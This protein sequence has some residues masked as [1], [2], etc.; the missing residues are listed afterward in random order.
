MAKS[1]NLKVGWSEKGASG[2]DA[3]HPKPANGGPICHAAAAPPPETH[4]SH[5]PRTKLSGNQTSNVSLLSWNCRGG[6]NSRTAR[7]LVSLVQT[8]S[9]SIVFLCETRQS[10]DRMKRYMPRLGLRG[11]DAVDTV[12]L[13]GGLALY[14]HESLTLDV[15]SMDQRHI[16]AYVS[17]AAGEPPW[18]LTCVYG[19]P[20]TENRHRMW[21]L[22]RDLHQQ[23]DI[24]W[25]VIGDFNEAMWGFEHFSE[26]PRSAGQMI[27]FCD[28]LELCGLGGLGFSGLPYTYDNRRHGRANVKVR[29]DMAVANNQWRDI[30][31]D[32]NV[33]HLVA[34]TSD[35]A[36]ILLRCFT[37]PPRQDNGRRCRHYEV[38]WERDA[39]LPEVIAQAW[40][41]AGAMGNLGDV[42]AALGELMHALHGWSKKKFGNV[43]KEIN[44]SRTRLEELMAMN[45]D[46]RTIREAT[47]RMNELLYREE[48][49]W[50]QRSRIDWLREGDRNTKFFH[51]RA[52]WRARKNRIK[53]LMDEAGVVQKDS[54][55]MVEMV[56]N[57]FSTLFTSDTSLCA[58]PI[59]DL[60]HARVTDIMNEGLCAD[61]SDKEIADA[62]F[63]IGP[64]KAPGPDGFPARMFQRNWSVMKDHVI[65]G[66]K[67]FFRIG[68]MPEGVNNTAIVLIPKVDNPVKLTDFRPISLCNVI[69]KVV[70]KC[71][72]NRLRPILDEIISPERSAFVPGRMITDNVLVAFECIHHIQQ[73]KDPARSFCAYKLD[74]SEAYD[75]DGEEKGLFTSLKADSHQANGVRSI[76]TT[77]EGATGQLI[78][79][80]KCSIM[81]GR[82]CSENDQNSVRAEL[83]V[84]LSTF[85]EKYLGLP[86]PDGRMSKG[87]CQNLQARLTKRMIAWGDTLSLAGKE[88][89]IKAVAQAIPTYM[90]GVFKLPMSVCDDLNRMVLKA[91]YYPEGRM[92][93]TVFTGNASVTWQSIQHG[94][95]LWRVRSGTQIRI[96]RDR[97]LPREP[98]GQL[99]TPQGTCRL[100][101]VSDLLGANGAW[102]VDVLRQYF[103][104]IDVDTI[105]SI[106]TSPRASDDVLAWAPEK[107]GVFSVRSAYRFAMDEREHPLASASSRAPDGRRAIWKTIWGCPAPPK[108]RVFAW[109]LVS[110]SLAIWANKFTRNLELNDL[111]PLCGVERED[112][113][114]AMCRCP[115]ARDLWRAVARDWPLPDVDEVRYTGPE[116]LLGVLDQ[117][118]EISRMVLLMVLW[119]IWHVRNEITHDK[120]PPSTESSRRFLQSYINSLLCIKQ[121]PQEDQV[122]GKM[123][124]SPDSVRLAPNQVKKQRACEAEMQRWSR[125]PDGWSKLNTDGSYVAANRTAGC[126]MVLRDAHGEIIFTACRQL[127]AC[128]NALDAELEACKEGLALALE[129]TT[130][131]IQVE[132]DC[133]EAVVMLQAT[134]RN[135]SRHMTI[136]SE[137]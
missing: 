87:K 113:F 27:D 23:A 110:N 52:V 65:A 125:P 106:K 76:I 88:T 136:V 73:E 118:P 119:R 36:P 53:S 98:S 135:R 18:R 128:D 57:Y 133:S 2:E 21:S 69:Y 85:E 67:E 102:K 96:W 7:D 121:F 124:L 26:T 45:A 86:T 54:T 117:L 16:D 91:R 42:A 90:M 61:F 75:R 15:K 39:A 22:L 44:K 62:L 40:A 38:A 10:K 84:Q 99:I 68:I 20:R 107:S 104:P 101:R 108:V 31:A 4:T 5:V 74:L 46:H 79:P 51:R 103:L 55:T 130:C 78:N 50:M 126:G 115:R 95:D 131:P 37:E 64:L 77:Y 81:F 105:T 63:Q 137:I 93:D 48:M 3:T 1:V 29:L 134:E 59:I 9:P 60:I 25:M 72:V 114:H 127:F 49:L 97:W 80:A 132:L 19:E 13:S 41:A 30:Y 12:G 11:F 83:Q 8:H 109:R 129:R 32:A 122:K 82:A 71:L 34:P 47:D 92:E 111:C 56:T 100:R 14:W 17:G 58:D 6:G 89:M 24:P 120:A 70:S 28:V 35:H 116:W 43:V 112:G 33:Q 123:V 66:V 94:L